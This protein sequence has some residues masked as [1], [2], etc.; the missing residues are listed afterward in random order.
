MKTLKVR[1]VSIDGDELES[2]PLEKITVAE[3]WDE[4]PSGNDEV[5]E[6]MADLLAE[7]VTL[8][9]ERQAV[10]CQGLAWLKLA[11]G[12]AVLTASACEGDVVV[13]IIVRPLAQGE[14]AWD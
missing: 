4:A 5:A 13:E 1:L 12:E 7:L 9:R 2:F 11:L 6:Y 3:E 14:N 8:L 10:A